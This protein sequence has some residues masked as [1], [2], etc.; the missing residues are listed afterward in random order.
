MENSRPRGLRRPPSRCSS[1]ATSWT[2]ARTGPGSGASPDRRRSP[3]APDGT[4]A[5]AARR[6]GG[7]VV[8][9][10]TEDRGGTLEQDPP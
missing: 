10:V 8:L 7:G 1:G 5:V 9:S 3:L 6:S 4:L 2:G